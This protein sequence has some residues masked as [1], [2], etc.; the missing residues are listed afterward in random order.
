[1]FPFRHPTA[2]EVGA[3]LPA[4]QSAMM[5]AY[6]PPAKVASY[7]LYLHADTDDD[8]LDFVIGWGKS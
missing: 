6:L 1:M 5:Q 7:A 8:K 2:P 4:P 3:V